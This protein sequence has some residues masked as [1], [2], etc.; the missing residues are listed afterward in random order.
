MEVVRVSLLSRNVNDAHLREIFSRYG[1]V[2]DACVVREN[3]SGYVKY[4]N[5]ECASKAVRCM[6]GGQIDGVVVRVQATETY[7]GDEPSNFISLFTMIE[8]HIVIYH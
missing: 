1:E 6:N 7:P 8:H 2:K 4:S 3:K 5:S